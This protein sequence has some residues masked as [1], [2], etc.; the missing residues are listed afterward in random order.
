MR[1]TTRLLHDPSFKW[2]LLASVPFNLAVLSHAVAAAWALTSLGKS[3]EIVALIPAAL[4]APTLFLA[5]WAGALADRYDKGTV[6][7]FSV[8]LA[9]TRCR[10]Q[11]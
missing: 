3:A 7:G 9:L 2:V 4:M 8:V 10:A 5:I 6:S 1:G 11:F